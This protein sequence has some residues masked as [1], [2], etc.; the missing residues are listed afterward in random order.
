MNR[1][2]HILTMLAVATIFTFPHVQAQSTEPIRIVVPFPVG[3]SS[4]GM[5]RLVAAELSKE[6]DRNVIV[7]SVPGG[8]GLLASRRVMNAPADG[9]TL[10][11]VAPTTMIILPKTT[12]LDFEPLEEFFPV[13]NLGSNPLVLSV[14]NS[15][16]A[17]SLQE[18]ITWVKSKPNNEVNFA[19]GGTGT[20]T[21]LVAELFFER[22]DVEL[23]HVPYKGGS[24]ALRDLLAGHVSAYFGNPADFLPH[25][26]GGVIRVLATSGEDRLAELPDVPALHETIPEL[27]LL[28]WNGLAYLK[29]TPKETVDRVSQAIQRIS[30]KPD[31]IAGMNRLGVTPIG[32]TP[33][34]FSAAIK[35]DR[36]LWDEAIEISGIEQ[37]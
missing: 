34:E 9:N 27:S 37:Q 11:V 22:A 36:E 14:H 13:S 23:T 1:A 26:D 5:A 19:S 6:L 32:N 21:H 12:K 3:G 20:S 10:L 2:K 25:A 33:E 17:S 18:F 8:S 31:Y 28:T 29:G 15:V 24:P 30:K 4:D 35:R 16:P 7:E